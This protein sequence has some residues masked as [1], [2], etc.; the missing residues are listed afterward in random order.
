[1]IEFFGAFLGALIGVFIPVGICMY[2][3][4]KDLEKTFKDL[5][6]VGSFNSTIQMDIKH[7]D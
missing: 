4:D 2:K 5:V 3:I 6:S 7:E 1:M